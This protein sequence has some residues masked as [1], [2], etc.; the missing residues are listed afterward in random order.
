MKDGPGHT[1]GAR[2]IDPWL[3]LE[4][5]GQGSTLLLFDIVDMCEP[6]SSSDHGS[7]VLRNLGSVVR[8][9]K[10]SSWVAIEGSPPGMR[11]L[12]SRVW[13]VLR[14]WLSFEV[15]PCAWRWFCILE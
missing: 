7:W 13:M 2:N 4:G 5:I 14:G 9:R 15:Y 1:I 11:G 6:R 12:R 8:W 10:V 3:I